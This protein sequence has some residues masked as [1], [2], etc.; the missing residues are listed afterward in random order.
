MLDQGAFGI[1]GIMIEDQETNYEVPLAYRAVDAKALHIAEGQNGFV[2]TIYVE[3]EYYMR[4]LVE[5]YGIDNISAIHRDLFLKGGD[6]AV[7]KKVRVLHAIEPRLD[8]DPHG[9]G[10]KIS[11]M[12]RFISISKPRRL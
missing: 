4:Q 9:F 11:R 10:D 6:E 5:K 12:H 7:G 1:S 8:A 3:R 2:D